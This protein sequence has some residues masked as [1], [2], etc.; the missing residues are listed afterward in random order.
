MHCAENIRL[1]LSFAEKAL[2]DDTGELRLPYSARKNPTT[3]NDVTPPTP[4]TGD[5]PQR[6]TT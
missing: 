3:H 5:P 2:I 4:A 1:I 6:E